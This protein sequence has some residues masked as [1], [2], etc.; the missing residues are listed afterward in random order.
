LNNNLNVVNQARIISTDSKLTHVDTAG[1]LT[2][3]DTAGKL[4][5]V[6]T[7]GKAKMVDVNSKESTCRIARASCVVNIGCEISEAIENNSMKKG[8]VLTVAQIAGIIGSKKTAELIPLCH[9]IPLSS[10]DV[11]LRLNKDDFTV[12]I[13]SEVQCHGK[14]GVE[15]EALM[16]VSVAAL[17]LYDMCKAMSHNIVI[18]NIQL[19][20]KSGGKAEFQRIDD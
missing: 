13:S 1:K 15:M 17:T 11:N 3:V 14:T 16:A 20:Y 2:N 19:D 7:A 5:H 6:D 12:L 9:N 4:T 10:V 8:D 18:E